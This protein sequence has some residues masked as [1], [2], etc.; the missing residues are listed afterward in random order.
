MSLDKEGATLTNEKGF[1]KF[2]DANN[3][4]WRRAEG[5]NDLAV[6]DAYMGR[7]GLE[8]GRI[9]LSKK[10]RATEWA[11]EVASAEA[12]LNRKPMATLRGNAPN[13]L[14]KLSSHPILLKR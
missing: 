1:E 13:D 12:S 14:E 2:L 11:P 6:V 4:V 3:T 9:R 10:L 5:R 8:L 7:L